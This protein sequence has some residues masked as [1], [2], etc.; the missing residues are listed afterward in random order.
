MQRNTQVRERHT[1]LPF[2]NP[3]DYL[4]MLYV[5]RAGLEPATLDS[6]N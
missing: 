1:L 6:T 3:A 5:L 4:K 2:G